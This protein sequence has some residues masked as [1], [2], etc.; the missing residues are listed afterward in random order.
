[1]GSLSPTQTNPVISESSV[2]LVEPLETSGLLQ[3]PDRRQAFL[4]WCMVT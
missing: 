1:M 4:P 3:F 2:I